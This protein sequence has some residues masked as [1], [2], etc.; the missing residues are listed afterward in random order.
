MCA[1]DCLP[2]SRLRELA[3][4]GVSFLVTDSS[5]VSLS[6]VIAINQEL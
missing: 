4:P 6:K 5:L 3:N 1:S 2:S